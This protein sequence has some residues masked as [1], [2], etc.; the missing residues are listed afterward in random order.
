MKWD[1]PKWLGIVAASL[2]G[3]ALFT[4]VIRIANDTS[5]LINS[6]VIGAAIGAS[7]TIA[8][9]LAIDAGRRK[10]GAQRRIKQLRRSLDALKSIAQM[11]NQEP[12]M[13]LPL[14]D[15]A[16][17][18]ATFLGGFGGGLEVLRYARGRIDIEDVNL[19][20]KLE[21][22]DRRFVRFN[23]QREIDK[24]ALNS[25]DIDEIGWSNARNRMIVF[26]TD[27]IGR[28][29]RVIAALDQKN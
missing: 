21:T 15:R 29:D 26:N 19:W 5:L 6:D 1:W 9:T 4:V 12:D 10:A 7:L 28:L 25:P 8:G 20:L 14:Q 16:I 3:A 11:A 24:T 22:L 17:E 13:T 18:T 23:K 2:V 27:I